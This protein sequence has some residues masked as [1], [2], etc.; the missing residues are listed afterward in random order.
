VKAVAENG[1]EYDIIF[2]DHTMPIMTGTEAS[3]QIRINGYKR[4]IL[5]VTGNALDDDVEAF[6][7]AGAD[8]VIAKPLRADVLDAVLRYIAEKGIDSDPKMKLN[9]EKTTN[10]GCLI[11]IFE[12][13]KI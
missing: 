10:N 2:M 7:E 1:H 5:G 8:C 4:L 9:T 3:R 12:H 6:L 11:K 13:L